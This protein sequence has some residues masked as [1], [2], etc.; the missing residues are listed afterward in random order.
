MA[1]HRESPGVSDNEMIWMNPDMPPGAGKGLFEAP[2]ITCVHCQKQ[3]IVNPKRTR[4]R[5]CCRACDDYICDDCA[6]AMKISGVHRNFQQ[7]MD[8]AINRVAK[9]LS[10]PIFERP[11]HG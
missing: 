1:D 4:E 9:G 5:P 7:V 8:D 3:L 2:V 11:S 10:V 6:F